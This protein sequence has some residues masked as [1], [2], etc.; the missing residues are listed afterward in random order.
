MKKT[1]AG[2]Q[3]QIS[4]RDSD[5]IYKTWLLLMEMTESHPVEIESQCLKVV[6][7]SYSQEMRYDHC[8]C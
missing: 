4:L 2:V 8:F 6:G 1:T 5:R 3:L 7:W